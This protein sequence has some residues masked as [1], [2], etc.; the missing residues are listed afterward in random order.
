VEAD[1]IGDS[2][3]DLIIRLAGNLNLTA[4]NFALTSAQYETDIAPFTTI[5]SFQTS[6]AALDQVAGGY[7]ILDSAANIQPNFA[8]L[9]A[10]AGHI[11]AV[12]L[13]SGAISVNAA[14]FAADQAVLNEIIGGFAVAD[15]GA[16]IQAQIGAL[17]Q[18]A[19]AIKSVTL[20]DSTAGSPDVLTLTAANV[21]ADAAA[22]GKIVSPY[23]LDAT[24][25]ASATLTGFGA[26]LTI[27]IG[28]GVGTV[29]GG[30]AGDVFYFS[31][32]FGATE[33]TDFSKYSASSRPDTIS[34]STSDFANWSTLLADGRQLGAN[35]VFT[36]TDG[37]S[38][39]VD[40]V[41]LTSLQ[42]A[43]PALQAEF[44]FHA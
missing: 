36:A 19:G 26:G 32:K 30:A 16:N 23:V 24:S 27:A 8:A 17:E 10:D 12:T 11:D 38:L 28:A 35:T 2:S 43:S 15:T 21:A 22:L 5:A 33:I 20:S 14:T 3:A 1:L 6:Q 40:G 39:T 42:H 31:S 37:C 34:L 44:K 41:S 9:E 13:T 29:T 7:S 18:D 25:A 4:A